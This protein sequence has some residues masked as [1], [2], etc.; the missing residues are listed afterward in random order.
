MARIRSIKPEIWTDEKFVE[1][2]P[3]ARLLFIGLWNFADDYGR[4]S[5]SPTRI[6]LQIL[7]ADST[8]VSELLGEIRRNGMVVVYIV[9][10]KEFL[11][12]SGWENHQK[13][14]KR[15]A[16]KYPSPHKTPPNSAEDSRK[17]ALDQG[18]DQGRDQGEDQGGEGSSPAS[19][20]GAK[21]DGSACPHQ[22][23]IALYHTH[24]PM[25]REV[26]TNLWNGTR[27]K[28]LQARWREDKQRQSIEWWENFFA[29]CAKSPFLTS[30]I[31]P[32]QGRTPFQVSLDWIVE[33][34]NFVKIIEGAYE[35]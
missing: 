24:L 26:K 14:D 25:G 27:A 31:P 1:L 7:P 3:L 9:E 11:Q 35:R 16:S 20:G 10:G 18:G 22:Q 13:V 23:I 2:S 17:K 29:Y 19:A 5:Y 8:E 28:H 34:G 33:P 21:P 6:K 32:R 12:I 15:S 4:M 30:Q